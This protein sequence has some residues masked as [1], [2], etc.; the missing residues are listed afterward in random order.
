MKKK[1]IAVMMGMILSA[2]VLSGCE[3]KDTTGSDRGSYSGTAASP[4]AGD[5]D[6]GNPGEADP[7]P[8]A[9][10]PEDDDTVYVDNIPD[11]I[12]AIKPGAKIVLKAGKYNINEYIQDVW[13]TD[14]KLWNKNHNYAEIREVFDGVELVIRDVPNLDIR[15]ESD[16]CADVEIVTDPRYAAVLSFEAC[17]KLVLSGMTLGHT[18]RGECWGSV[19]D[20]LS[21]DSVIL[22]NMDLY[23]CG[24]IGLNLEYCSNFLKCTDVTIRDCS[25]GP[26]C[27]SGSRGEWKFYNCNLT[28]S[29]SGGFF[30]EAPALSLYFEN[31]TFGDRES[32]NF[33]FRED[34]TTK[35]CT[36]G[37]VS[38]PPDYSGYDSGAPD[39]VI[40]ND[41]K[42]TSFDSYMLLYREWT[43]FE[44]IDDTTG[45]ISETG[46][47]VYFND[48]GTGEIYDD[49]SGNEFTWT[50]DSNYSAVITMDDG[51]GE[52]G[53]TIY[54]DKTK[55]ESPLFMVLSQNGK[56][57]WYY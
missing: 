50:L 1:I 25:S 49:I 21:C 47:W 57:S 53:V 13:D 30:S 38:T 9:A 10:Q 33:M 35:N 36:W 26:L 27:N 20:L 18:D 19:I 45:E 56:S 23:G 43:G 6:P 29:D 12:Q 22:N 44:I 24:V 41:M 52:Y 4:T 11:L 14:P 34:T 15:G 3:G 32:E 42:V 5:V 7:T 40:V 28:G 2:A 48:D 17:D 37:N 54:I 39:A 46:Q 51:S 31:C 55:Q 16:N 8:T